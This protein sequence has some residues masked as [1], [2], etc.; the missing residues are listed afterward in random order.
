M[1][2]RIL[3]DPAHVPEREVLATGA[4][5][6]LW[7][8]DLAPLVRRNIYRLGRERVVRG[9]LAPRSRA[10]G[11]NVQRKQLCAIPALSW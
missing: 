1:A 3:R 9:R 4:V 10:V 7:W 2:Y 6:G 8:T 11:R 5:A